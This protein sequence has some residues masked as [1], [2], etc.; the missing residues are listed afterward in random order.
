MSRVVHVVGLKG[1]VLKVLKEED[2]SWA[3]HFFGNESS[4]VCVAHVLSSMEISNEQKLLYDILCNEKH[5]VLQHSQH[6]VWKNPIS[7]YSWVFGLFHLSSPKRCY[8]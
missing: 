6:I 8:V 2:L 3:V 4:L 5:V 7:L 1:D